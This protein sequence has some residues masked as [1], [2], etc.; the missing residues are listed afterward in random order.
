MVMI[1]YG[2]KQSIVRGL[3]KVVALVVAI[4][5]NICTMFFNPDFD[6]VDAVVFVKLQVLETER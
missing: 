4:M 5:L 3:F 1:A 2:L 6:Y